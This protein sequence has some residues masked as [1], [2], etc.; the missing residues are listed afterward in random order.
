MKTQALE[1]YIRKLESSNFRMMPGINADIMNAIAEELGGEP[2]AVNM[3]GP[4]NKDGSSIEQWK[5]YCF[6]VVIKSMID[7]VNGD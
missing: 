6:L 2:C 3:S 5:M 4:F 7:K 1:D